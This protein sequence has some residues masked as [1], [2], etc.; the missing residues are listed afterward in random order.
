MQPSQLPDFA[1]LHLPGA[2]LADCICMAVELDTRGLVLSDTQRFNVSPAI[3]LPTICWVFSGDLQCVESLDDDAPPRFSPA[4]ARVCVAGPSSKPT[5]SWSPGPVYALS[6][7]LYPE[8]WSRLLGV[9][10]ADWLDVL[11]PLDA[12]PPSAARDALARVSADGTESPFAQIQAALLPLWRPNHTAAPF[13]GAT[14]SGWLRSLAVRAAFSRAGTSVRQAQRRFRDWT[15][16]SQRELQL[17]ARLKQ[18]FVLLTQGNALA[19]VAHAAGYSDQSHLG[20][21]IK[22]VTGLSPAHFAERVQDDEGFW[23]YRLLGD[24]LEKESRPAPLEAGDD[25]KTR[26]RE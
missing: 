25:T 9:A 14:M 19:D 4:P 21:E 20:R 8:S 13:G 18:A 10:P 2:P 3:P 11:A 7:A 23:M 1:R 15:G 5:A 26:A 24:H 6:I 22:R 12:L 17:F 16:Q